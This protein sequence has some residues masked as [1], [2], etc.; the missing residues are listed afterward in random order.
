[1]FSQTIKNIIFNNLLEKYLEYIPDF[2]M[3]WGVYEQGALTPLYLIP[4]LPPLLKLGN[5]IQVKNYARVIYI[6]QNN[7]CNCN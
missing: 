1:M 7:N 5:T 6:P 4:L 2:I 3:P